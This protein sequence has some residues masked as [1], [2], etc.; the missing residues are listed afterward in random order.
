MNSR[1]KPSDLMRAKRPYL[2]SDSANTDAYRLSRSELSHH[3]D[4]LTDRNQHKDFENFA[5]RLCERE[6]CP[7]LRPQTGP[8]GGGDGKVDTETYPVDEKIA[9]RWFV[10]DRSDRQAKLGF[11]FSA[12][13]DWKNKVRSDVEGIVGTNRGYEKIF[14]V[15]S[16]PTRAKDRLCV[17][18]ELRSAHG[19]SVT[20]WDR[21][22]ILDRVFLNDHKDLAFKCLTAGE[23]DPNSVKLGPNDFK[24]QQALTAIEQALAR[25]GVTQSDYTQAVSDTYE[26]ATLSRSLERPRYETEGRFQRAIGFAKKYGVNYQHLRAI[27]QLAWTRFWWFDDVEASQDLYEQ[28]EEISFATNYAEHVSKVFNLHQ[29]LVGQV[30]PGLQDSE[31]LKL[32]ERSSRLKAKLV[33]LAGDKSRPNNALYAEALLWLFRIN[34]NALGGNRDNF[35]DIWVG[36]STIIDRAAGLGE[37]PAEM[38]DSVVEALSPLAPVSAEFDKLVEKLAEFMAD[39]SKELKAA[40]IYL[41]Q[42]ERK[43]DADKPIESIKYLGRSVVNFMKE[44]SREEQ[45][46]ALYCLAIGYRGAGLLWAARGA[47]MGAITQ[48]CAQAQQD[49][50]IPVEAV[51]TFSLFTMIALQLGHVADFLS[52]IQFL[53]AAKDVLPLDDASR[54]RLANKFTE[55]DQLL[56]CLFS[57]ICNG[58]IKRL[59]EVPDI[60]DALGLFM[61]R[62]VLLYRLGHLDKLK[63]DGSIPEGT[64]D[65]DILDMMSTIAAQPASRDLPKHIVLMG[66]DST[67]IETRIMGINFQVVAEGNRNGFLLAEAH[68]SFLE[69]FL[70]TLL[71]S[72][73]FAHREDLQ[74]EIMQSGSSTEAGIEFSATDGKLTVTLP[75]SWNPSEV[76]HHAELNKHL[77]EFGTHVL[78]NCF[79]L[80]APERVLEQLLGIERAFERAALFC[81]TGMSRKRALGNDVGQ[82]AEWRHLV[83]KTY[84]FQNDAPDIKPKKLSEQPGDEKAGIG[85][86]ELNSHRDLAVSS[87]IN[88]ALWDKAGWQGMMYGHAGPNQPPLLGLIFS[89]AEMANAIFEEWQD[90]F[91]RDD[92]NDEIRISIVKGIDRKNPYYY[93]GCISRDMDVISKE[94]A[95][96]IVSVSRMTT[97]TVSDHKNL[98]LFQRAFATLGC[99][100]LI[101][102]I[103][104]GDGKPQLLLARAILKRKFNVREA[105]QI[106]PHDLD[107]VAIKPKDDVIIPDGEESPPI[108][109]LF[110]WRR[111]KEPRQ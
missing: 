60:L 48:V 44:E 110:E 85:L 24:N 51:P 33:E 28:V 105:W 101:P 21:E 14:F 18:D 77:V 76:D 1:P 36:L 72:E 32:P 68:I 17:E 23:Y 46:R 7:N 99:Y 52:G 54:E 84:A 89:S 6:I 41:S 106:G 95:R 78:A 75:D 13:Q 103:L 39:R 9:E 58:D 79:M 70:S 92:A 40:R 62:M 34:E 5:R 59:T 74:V 2:Y 47:A 56:S 98:D 3:L 29:L 100:F 12:K 96:R 53:Y 108:Y 69:A 109:E 55:F 20:I 10:G 87:I 15:T 11:A 16:R 88:Q 22:L 25:M 90:R 67:K 80:P 73:A 4:T 61:A 63:S 30:L 66:N 91:G 31:S 111:G 43:L 83:E 102:A 64:K 107:C 97:M 26:A 50:E 8:E 93:R 57:V 82:I 49:G 42:G 38:L 71:N 35:D 104:D 27:Y 81:R 19:V 37:F 86:G 94:G 45:G 65:S